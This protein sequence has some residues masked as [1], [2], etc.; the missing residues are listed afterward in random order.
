MEKFDEFISELD[1]AC[2]VKAVYAEFRE[3]MPVSKAVTELKREFEDE[4][5]DE[6]DGPLFWLGLAAGMAE[7]KELTEAVKKKALSYF[8]DEAFLE[9]YGEMADFT[10]DDVEELKAYFDASTGKAK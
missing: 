2:D 3:E 9:R 10:A 7:S 5:Q 1:F 6:D 8:T 4:R